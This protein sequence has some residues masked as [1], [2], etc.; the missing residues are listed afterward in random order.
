MS[1]KKPFFGGILVGRLPGETGSGPLTQ[2]V[3][4]GLFALLFE[5]SCTLVIGSNILFGFT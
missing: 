2:S 4:N 3:K 5:D 1:Y